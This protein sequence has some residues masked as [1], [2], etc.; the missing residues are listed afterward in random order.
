MKS[1]NH[2]N[3][4]I[5]QHFKNK[6]C[7][8][9]NYGKIVEDSYVIGITENPDSPFVF[10]FKEAIKLPPCLEKFCNETFLE[11]FPN[12]KLLDKLS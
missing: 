4:T 7:S 6:I 5:L 10:G 1:V 3:D 8:H 12:C 2:I 11:Y 9:I